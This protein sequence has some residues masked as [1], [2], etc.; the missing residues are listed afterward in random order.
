[1]SGPVAD[2]SGT[3]TSP[4][5]KSISNLPMWRLRA[6]SEERVLDFRGRENLRSFCAKLAAGKM[7]EHLLHGFLH[8]FRALVSQAIDIH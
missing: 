6:I 5:E 1:M 8:Q 7:T 4:V 2:F 3:S